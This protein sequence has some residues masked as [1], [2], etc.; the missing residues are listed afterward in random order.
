M[1]LVVFLL[2]LVKFTPLGVEVN[3]A[4]RWMSIAGFQF[5]PSEMA[6]LSTILL[7]SC[8][9]YN[10]TNLFDNEKIT[11]Y[12]LPIVL[13]ILFIF[14]QPNLSMVM[15]L[16][17][18]SIAMYI[19]AGGSWRFLCFFIVMGIIV[20]KLKMR[21]YQLGRLKI[22]LNPET[23]PLGAGY[24]II[25]SLIA[26]AVG[27]FTGVGYGNSKQKLF[28]LPE[29]HTDFIFAVFAEEFGFIGCLFV[30]GLFATF[31]QRGFII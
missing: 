4:K 29:C 22:W 30:I 28:W 21:K 27:G 20:L 13:M 15:L 24:N 2:F 10:N 6:K 3:N 17:I 1:W 19:C 5:Q 18:T 14:A 25:Q 11:K 12:F 26:F 9:F 7:L 23:D 8:A 31:M 16:V